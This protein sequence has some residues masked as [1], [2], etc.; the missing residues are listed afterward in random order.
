MLVTGTVPPARAVLWDG[1]G[2]NSEWI[3]PANWQFNM[4]PTAADTA[5]II[6]DTATITGVVV[7]PVF[8][9]ELGLGSMPGGLVIAGGVNPA[10]LNVVTNVAVASAGSLT[11]GG[12]GPALSHMTAGSL[13]IS[14]NV[15]VLSLGTVNLSGSLTQTGGTMTLNGGMINA[16]T[17]LCR[18]GEFNATG[19]VNANVTIGNGSGA[20]AT[21][22]PVASLAIDGDLKL[23]SDARLEV[24]FR[25]SIGGDG[26][27]DM[28]DASGTATLG[29][30]LD[31]SILG[32]APT[33][34]VTYTV[35]TAGALE[36][37]FDDIRGLQTP[38]GSWVPHFDSDGSF[39]GMSFKTT[40]LR[41]DMNGDNAVTELDV[42]KFAWAIRDANT[43]HTQFVLN[44]DAAASHMAD[45][46]FDGGNTF[47]DIPMFLDAVEQSGGSV[48]AA[49]AGLARVL[50]PAPEP[51][52]GVL[53]CG[54]AAQICHAVRQARRARGRPT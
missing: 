41:G 4:L 1:G 45:M 7:P 24:Q 48:P 38:T 33:P 39:T 47:A 14:G 3:E 19:D 36:G 6:N 23:A 18:A 22:H 31:I 50:L 35:L 8:A 15:T 26:V 27:F 25:P 54:M 16:A 20:N 10:G 9:T 17:V 12:G 37:G 29:G 30:T 11:L 49:E 44:G 21:L 34:G 32:G 5:T 28:I 40:S 53:V 46:D 2:V 13:S 43:Y 51:Q 52:A 42:E